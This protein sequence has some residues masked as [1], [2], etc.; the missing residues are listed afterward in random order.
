MIVGRDENSKQRLWTCSEFVVSIPVVYLLSVGPAIWLHGHTPH[1]IQVL[2]EY[3]YLPIQWL[4]ESWEEPLFR[5]YL[6]WC[7]NL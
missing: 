4:S 7:R 3:C 6:N 2:L 5:D 1:L